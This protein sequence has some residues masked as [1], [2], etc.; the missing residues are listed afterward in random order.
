ML[1]TG[2]WLL[3]Y[4]QVVSIEWHSNHST[5]HRLQPATPVWCD[6]ED[7]GSPMCQC[8]RDEALQGQNKA[9]VCGSS[10][11]LCSTVEEGGRS[12]VV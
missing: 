1:F 11:L 8:T 12:K 2:E 4:V 5:L 7:G 9:H 6:S 3:I 10:M